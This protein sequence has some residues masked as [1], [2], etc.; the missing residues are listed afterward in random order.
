MASM[1]KP[2][3]P[4]CKD[5]RVEGI[6]NTRPVYKAGRCRTHDRAVQKARRDRAHAQRVEK[7]YG[8]AEGEYEAL[9]A[10][11]GGVCALCG[12]GFARRRGSVDHDHKTGEVRGIIHGWEN[13]FIG[14]IRDSLDWARRLVAYLENS[15]ARRAGLNR[16]PKG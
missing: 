5:C 1:A 10:F 6:P 7:T 2:E 9:L 16:I 13:T 15:P 8:L 11:Q 3:R 12:K 4:W 14:R